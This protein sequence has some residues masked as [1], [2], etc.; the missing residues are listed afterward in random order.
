MK[1]EHYPH[2]CMEVLGNKLRIEILCLLEKKP[3]TVQQVC[4]ELG[5]EQSLVSHA[6]KQMKEC[7]F[8]DFRKEGKKSIYY[9]KSDIFTK[10]KNKPLFD[11]FEEHAKK[12]CKHKK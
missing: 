2:K 12:Y 1:K 4:T 9:I 3:R 10:S 6:L 7:S 5:R 8:V 11:I